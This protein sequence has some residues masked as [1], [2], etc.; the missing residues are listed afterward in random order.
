MRKS[1]V[2][3]CT[4]R[5]S[6]GHPLLLEHTLANS[7]GRDAV[8]ELR[9]SH[10][11]ELAAVESLQEL[12][13]LQQSVVGGSVVSTAAGCVAGSCGGGAQGVGGSPRQQQQPQLRQLVQQAVATGGAGG[14]RELARGGRIFLAAHESVVIPFRLALNQ[15]GQDSAAVNG[16]QPPPQHCEQQQPHTLTVEFVP[17]GLDWPVSILE[18]TI[19]PEPPIVDR[20][21]RYHCPEREL[22]HVE[23][24]LAQLPG[25][26]AAVLAAAAGGRLV[27][28]AS[29]ADV[30]VTVVSKQQQ[31]GQ[32]QQ[33]VVC[34]RYRCGAASQAAA[35]Q[36]YVWLYGD[37]AAAQ[38]LEAW[39]V[40]GETCW[41]PG[42]AHDSK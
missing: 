31:K 22:L 26:S 40:S 16:Q 11:H 29:R 41:L 13:D 20:T 28:A 3:Q 14:G 24:L 39:Q 18:L 5:P 42:F 37:P 19:Q 4:L 38:P 2:T 10:P 9:V 23:L 36:F 7:I 32:Q 30:G 27:V 17:L 1:L 8:F 21:L 12:R 33:D 35:V 15:P 34:L 6:P 25:V